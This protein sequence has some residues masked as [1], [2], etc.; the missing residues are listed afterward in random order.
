MEA[1]ASDVANCPWGTYNFSVTG[2]GGVAIGTGI[3]NT[4]DIVAGD[5]LPNKAADICDPYGRFGGSDRGQLLSG[6]ERALG[7]RKRVVP[8]PRFTKT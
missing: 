7:G 5:P 8:L 2:A 1:A 6:K 3:Q 4:L